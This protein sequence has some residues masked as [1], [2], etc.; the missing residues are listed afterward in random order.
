MLILEILGLT[1]TVLRRKW[2]KQAK[3]RDGLR[4]MNLKRMK[5]STNNCNI[6]ILMNK[7]QQVH[8]ASLSMPMKVQ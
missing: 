1:K 8:L 5:I 6:E 7:T 3:I 2:M 4:E